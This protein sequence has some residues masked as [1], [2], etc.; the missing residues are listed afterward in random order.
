MYHRAGAT[1]HDYKAWVKDD[2]H[3]SNKQNLEGGRTVQGIMR[4]LHERSNNLMKL[5]GETRK[6]S[7]SKPHEKHEG[8]E[9]LVDR[10]ISI[11]Q[12]HSR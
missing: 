4:S 11:A 7:R 2:N 10:S 6:S 12:S 1:V 9:K 5:E 3:L 8:R